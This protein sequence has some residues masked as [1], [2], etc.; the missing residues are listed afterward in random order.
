MYNLGAWQKNKLAT[1]HSTW[2]LES[3][4]NFKGKKKKTENQFILG[5]P[6]FSMWPWR[7]SLVA[8]LKDFLIKYP[9]SKHHDSSGVDDG[10]SAPEQ[11]LGGPLFTVQNEGDGLPVHADGHSVPPGKEGRSS[12][13]TALLDYTPES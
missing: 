7:C 8:Y 10:V 2:T 5:P 4:Y 11:P 9:G 1:K 13:L 6:P 3:N 12:L